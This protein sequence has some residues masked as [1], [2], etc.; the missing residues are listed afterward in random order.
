MSPYRSRVP[1]LRDVHFRI[2]E[3]PDCFPLPDDDKIRVL[4]F[5]YRGES[6]VFFRSRCYPAS[7]VMNGKFQFYLMLAT[8]FLS[9]LAVS[10]TRPIVSIH[11]HSLG[12]STFFIGLLVS[13]FAAFPLILAIR[14]GKWTDRF[15]TK[16]LTLWG[17]TGVLAA[18]AVPLW[19]P[20]LAGLLFS[21]ICMGL[22]NNCIVTATQKRV[23]IVGGN[24]DKAVTGMTTTAAAA[25]FVSPLTGGF[26]YEHGGIRITFLVL[27][28]IQIM[29]LALVR[30]MDSEPRRDAAST[31]TEEKKNTLILLKDPHIR[32]GVLV[33]GIVV[34]SKDIFTAYFP[35]LAAGYGFSPSQTGT[36]LACV[37]AASVAVRLLQFKLV[38]WV[39]RDKLMAAA[40]LAGAAAFTATSMLEHPWLLS[41][42]AVLL[43][44]GLGLVQPLSWVYL[45]QYTPKGREGEVLGLRSMLNRSWQLSGPL[46]LG[47]VG[48][49]FGLLPVFWVCGLTLLCGSWYSHPVSLL[50][51]RRAPGTPEQAE[52]NKEA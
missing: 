28:V 9:N 40:L 35:V 33:S 41:A 50:P 26:L 27:L 44:A 5:R 37:A 32:K 16:A 31:R 36:V 34:Y 49:T 18:L 13:A 39:D 52:P 25:D 19:Q 1:E 38:E 21:Q 10:G 15:G 14:I 42:T 23:S 20:T 7:P 46:M 30:M 4:L 48:H 22:S 43:G 45:I 3:Q 47:V 17:G 51:L 29:M 12:A 24:R 11:A 8:F 6:R 2:T